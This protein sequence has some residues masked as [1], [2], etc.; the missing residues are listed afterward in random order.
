MEGSNGS[1][2]EE[3]LTGGR[4]VLAGT[5][6]RMTGMRQLEERIHALEEE[7]HTY[8]TTHVRLAEVLDLVQELLLPIAQRDEAKVAELVD[9]F[10]AELGD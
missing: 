2:P 7:L 6:R 5:F 1:A 10:A 9:K 3:K 8:Q 4:F